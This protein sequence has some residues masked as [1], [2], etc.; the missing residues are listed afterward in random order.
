M[1]QDNKLELKIC[2]SMKIS[3]SLEVDSH[4]PFMTLKL[5]LKNY[6]MEHIH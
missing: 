4:L 3:G 5:H 6:I 1:A 2:I